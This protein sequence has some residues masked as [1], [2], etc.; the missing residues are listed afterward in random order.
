MYNSEQKVFIRRFQWLYS[1]HV[2]D[3]LGYEQQM[4]QLRDMAKEAIEW[5]PQE[6]RELFLHFAVN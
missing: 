1:D 2:T 3:E 5:V 6:H 4:L